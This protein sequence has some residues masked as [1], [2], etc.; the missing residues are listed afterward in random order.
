MRLMTMV[1]VVGMASAAQ[2][3]ILNVPSSYS[4][5]PAAIGAAS[6][7]DT[8]LVAPGTYTQNV[9]FGGKTLALRSV[10]GPAST[11]IK[12][13]GGVGVALGGS[14]EV[15]GFTITGAK[16]DFGA[17]VRVSGV[18]TL[19]KGNILDSNVETAGGF[20]AAIGGNGAS[21]II[22]GNVFK[23]NTADGQF[24]SGVVCFVN[25]SSPQIF[26]NLFTS[27]PTR[28][29][30]FILPSG[31]TPLVVN[32]TFVG[33]STAINYGS[34]SPTTFRN[35]VLV[36]NVN[37]FVLD[38]PGMLPTWENNDVFNNTLNYT[39]GM[40][41]QTG[42]AGNLSTDP[43]FVSA[44]DFHLKAASPL[45]NAGSPLLA[46]DHDFDGHPRPLFGGVDMGAYELPEPCGVAVIAV[47]SV[48]CLSRRR[49][50]PRQLP[51]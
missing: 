13:N 50:R 38:Y 42:L 47:A 25:G 44:T 27:N 24:L 39:G 17:G 11:I 5:I 37:G 46:P 15:S 4:T 48:C 10:A 43:L 7:G 28:A 18:G 40:P 22:D 33:N 32:N 14:S 36:G 20:G 16:A 23:N 30:N 41:D 21:P 49:Q 26:N 2:A 3:A 12:V 9:D 31:N 8:I 29:I 51:A 19:I 35:N 1:L 45:I 6:S 34:F